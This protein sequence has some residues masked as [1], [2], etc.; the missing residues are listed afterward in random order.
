[1]AI[2]HQSSNPIQLFIYIALAIITAGTGLLLGMPVP[3]LCL[4]ILGVSFYW[5]SAFLITLDRHTHSDCIQ[6]GTALTPSF[7]IFLLYGTGCASPYPYVA[8][9]F[10]TLVAFEV[11]NNQVIKQQK[12]EFPLWGTLM[13]TSLAAVTAFVTIPKTQEHVPALMRSLNGWGKTQYTAPLLLIS[14]LVLLICFL[15]LIFLFRKTFALYAHGS[16]Y[17]D[18]TIPAER[19]TGSLLLI[20]KSAALTMAVLILGIHMGIAL[21][22]WQISK[23]RYAAAE[24]YGASLFY[25]FFLTILSY[26]G[27]YFSAISVSV[28][29]SYGLYAYFHRST[30]RLPRY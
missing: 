5:I 25:A 7:T 9:P 28:I 10:I 22:I 11:F 15:V 16:F 6:N 4:V 13:Q 3:L 30:A 20:L 19:M 23:T 21:Y 1:M 17:Y 14:L 29:T 2:E 26:L 18:G 12:E 24:S 27:Y 8:V